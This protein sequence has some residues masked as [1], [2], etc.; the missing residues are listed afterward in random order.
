M[1]HLEFKTWPM[2][3]HYFFPMSIGSMSYVELKGQ[4][5]H[6]YHLAGH[7]GEL[8]FFLLIVTYLLNHERLLQPSV[9][10]V[11]TIS[12]TQVPA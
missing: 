5:P 2:S 8:I 12:L 11:F 1:S 9:V 4:G 7:Q 3:C 6:N 10:L